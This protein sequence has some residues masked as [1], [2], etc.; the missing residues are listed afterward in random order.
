[1][2]KLKFACPYCWEN[3]SYR[4]GYCEVKCSVCNIIF[5][6]E[7]GKIISEIPG[8]CLYDRYNAVCEAA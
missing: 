3:I 6:L 8:G 4:Y 1:M 5:I 2:K 7:N